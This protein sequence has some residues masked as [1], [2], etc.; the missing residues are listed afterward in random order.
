MFNRSKK[1]MSHFD[2]ILFLVTLI[3]CVFGFIVV[4]SAT[5][6][7]GG[8][9]HAL[10]SQFAATALGVALIVLLQ[11]IDVDYMKKLAMPIYG[12][13]VL[14]LIATMLFGVGEDAWG[15][16]SW[17][18]LGP[19]TFQPAEFTKIAVMI[20]FAMLLERY[21]YRL[22]KITTLLILAVAMG[23]PVVLI[24]RQP[25]FGTAAVFI[26]FLALMIFYA[27][28]HWGYIVAALVLVAVATPI[29]YQHLS[30]MQQDRILNFLNPMR[31][32]MKSGYQ[33]YQ[34]LIAI[35][36]GKLFGKGFLH[37][38]QTQYGFIPE[39]DTD[40]IFAVLAEE[41]GLVGAGVLIF[42]YAVMLLRIL[43]ISKRAKD[44]F[45]RTLCVGVAAMQ[46]IH[47]FENIGM[48]IGVMPLTGIPLPFLSNGGTFQLINLLSIGMILCISTQRKPLDFNAPEP[49][50]SR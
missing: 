23:I 39:R 7:R 18:K 14:L 27:G 28:L 17:L 1:D 21:Q 16:R 20:A 25:D 43:L 44:M 47:I 41:F 33:T 3:L 12:I 11:Y 6:S 31:D 45:S 40:Y 37:G 32:V 38:T 15:A 34:G 49:S 10:K 22:N 24:L 13:A 4:F 50:F 48:T 9:W 35:G 36:S 19:V 8:Q 30:P 46:F 26:F 2:W 29:V 5:V 42:L